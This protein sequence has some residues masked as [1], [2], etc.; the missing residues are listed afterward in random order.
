M[1]VCAHGNVADFCEKREMY[2]C[3][4]WNGDISDYNGFCRVLVTDSDISESE[5]Y[6]L[7]GELLARGVELISTRYKD[8]KLMSK[9]L[10]YSAVRRKAKPKGRQSEDVI[11]RI[12]ELRDAGLSIRAIRE[13]AQ[14]HNS[15]GNRLSISTI[16]KIIE[17][18][19]KYG[20]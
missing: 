15:E 2:I 14:V 4:E 9:Y 19:S 18:R 12:Y 3:E 6:F 5:Y 16:S 20:K 10:A 1:M 8:D 11:R 13:D 7:K 17:R